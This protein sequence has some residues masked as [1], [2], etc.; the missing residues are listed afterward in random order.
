LIPPAE[1]TQKTPAKKPAPSSRAGA[2]PGMTPAPVLGWEKRLEKKRAYSDQTSGQIIQRAISSICDEYGMHAKFVG[3]TAFITTFAGEWF[4]AYNDRPIRLRHKN[5]AERTKKFADSLDY[6]HLQ[7]DRFPSPLHALK[8]IFNH[9]MELKRKIMWEADSELAADQYYYADDGTMNVISRAVIFAAK[10]H[11]NAVRKG[12]GAP[13]ILHPLEAAVIVASITDDE[14]VIAAALL[15]DVL[16]DTEVKASELQVEFGAR[17]RKLVEGESEDKRPHLPA[18]ETWK[19]RKSETIDHLYSAASE[20]ECII[21]LAD[22]LS[23]LRACY[24]DSQ[25][26][27]DALW[28]K[29]NVKD[30]AMHAWYYKAVRDALGKLQD[31]DAWMELS[32]LVDKLFQD[33]AGDCPEDEIE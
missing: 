13:Y 30:K 32:A 3:G 4:F 11:K 18:E 25:E 27:G 8:Y 31:T 23:N 15:H 19:E 20:E 7:Y 14:E 24:R 22:K 12:A 6:Y 33:G 17:V 29:F 2:K 28:E 21:A 10:A 9:D 16:E 1:I 5:Y 26:H